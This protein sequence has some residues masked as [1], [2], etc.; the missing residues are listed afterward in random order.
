ML[1]A[2]D[3]GVNDHHREGEMQTLPPFIMGNKG[4][5]HELFQK[6]RL[7]LGELLGDLSLWELE[8]VHVIIK[9][10]PKFSVHTSYIS[11]WYC[12]TVA[13]KVHCK[14][15]FPSESGSISTL[16]SSHLETPAHRLKGFFSVSYLYN[17]HPHG[18]V[19]PLSMSNFSNFRIRLDLTVLV[20]RLTLIFA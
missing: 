10:S 19:H 18:C 3:T 14:Q 20:A 15:F 6:L 4:A 17:T 9:N 5:L 2:P 7:T 1:G 16:S 12:F 13:P 11:S 8:L